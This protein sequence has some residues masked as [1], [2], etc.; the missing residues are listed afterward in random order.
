M[1]NYYSTV[2][3][4]K[5]GVEAERIR[6]SIV[7]VVFGIYILW[8]DRF[9]RAHYQSKQSVPK[10]KASDNAFGAQGA[11]H[12]PPFLYLQQRQVEII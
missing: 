5:R 7:Y 3:G 6:E 4:S 1:G 8:S 12:L 2:K 10:R 11:D 9:M